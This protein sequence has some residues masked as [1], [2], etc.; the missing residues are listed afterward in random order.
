MESLARIRIARGRLS[1]G[2]TLLELLLVIAIV[3]VMILFAF[4]SVKSHANQAREER[5]ASE[6]ETVMQST[7]Y[8]QS[9]NQKWPADNLAANCSRVASS[10]EFQTR[11]LPNGSSDP[12]QKTVF[13]TYYCWGTPSSVTDPDNPEAQLNSPLFDI[14]LKVV[15]QHA[16]QVAKRIAGMVPN[17]IAL[18]ELAATQTSACANETSYFVRAEVGAAS[19]ATT[20]AESFKSMGECVPDDQT[21]VCDSDSQFANSSSACCRV[22]TPGYPATQYQI[23]FP[24][25]LSGQQPKVIYMPAFITYMHQGDQ[26]QTVFD[27]DFVYSDASQR[28]PAANRMRN[29]VADCHKV[30]GMEHE[31]VCTLTL[32]LGMSTRK[33]GVVDITQGHTVPKSSSNPAPAYQDGSVGAIYMTSCINQRNNGE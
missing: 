29:P 15:S 2:F 13:G 19:A 8:Y 10:D 26:A 21:P 27:R 16:C 3:A 31:T 12:L 7:L 14:Y 24:S 6:L 18:N 30:S 33:N 20:S 25:C 22:M 23:H 11:Y 32:G 28:N 1:H 5:S 17:A 4:R 9:S